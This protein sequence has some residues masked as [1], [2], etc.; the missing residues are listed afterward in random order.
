MKTAGRVVLCEPAEDRRIC[1]LLPR[2]I[3][4]HML[5]LSCAWMKSA[6]KNPPVGP[7]LARIA[8]QNRTV[9]GQRNPPPQR[10]RTGHAE[11]FECLDRKSYRSLSEEKMLRDLVREARLRS[12]ELGNRLGNNLA[13]SAYL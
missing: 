10:D 4:K 9:T 5:R 1:N 12:S 2:L 7:N 13:K 3:C 11:I 8:E 6:T